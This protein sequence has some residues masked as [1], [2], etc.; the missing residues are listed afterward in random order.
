[1][2]LTNAT[3]ATNAT[4][5][6]YATNAMYATN[7]NDNIIDKELVIVNSENEKI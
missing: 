6:T 5:A 7:A 4:Y 2:S 3:N 1:M